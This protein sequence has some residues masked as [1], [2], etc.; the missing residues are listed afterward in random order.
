MED[1]HTPANKHNSQ[2]AIVAGVLNGC[3]HAEAQMC[4]RY[5]Q[6]MRRVLA[7]YADNPADADDWLNSSW[8]IALTKIR[9]G[10]LRD[11]DCLA[12]FLCGIARRV[13]AGA[14]RQRW[15]RD[16]RPASEE[17]DSRCSEEDIYRTISSRELVE[18]TKGLVDQLS[19]ERDRQLFD[20]CFFQG[21]DKRQV[22][23]TMDMDPDHLGKVLYRARQRLWAAAEQAG[24]ANSLRE[25]LNDAT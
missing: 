3:P 25:L 19:V 20:S 15:H 12:G 24:M 6:S 16:T 10:D 7:R 18:L 13:A 21:R 9:Q 14:L 5:E 23:A 11:P 22:A 17:L 8:V 1:K 4:R 2:A